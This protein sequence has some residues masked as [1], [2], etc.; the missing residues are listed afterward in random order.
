MGKRWYGSINNTLDENRMLCKE[1]KVGTKV[2]EY[3]YS[4]RNPY[5]VTKV[6]DQKHVFIRAYKCIP[7]GEPMSNNWAIISNPENP[8]I[9]I[10]FVW[11]HWRKV[12][13]NRKTEKISYSKMNLSF[14]V[15]EKYYDYE[16]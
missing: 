14:G 7:T 6:I 12:L 11:H 8:E 2:T 1:I 9:E 5:E 3:L 4:D 13:K 15:A 16:F 10:K